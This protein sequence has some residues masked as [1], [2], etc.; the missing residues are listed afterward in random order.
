MIAGAS[1]NQWAEMQSL[2]A[3]ELMGIDG[4]GDVMA[5]GYVEFF[6]DEDNRAAVKDLLGVLTLD[7]SFEESGS[8]LA[9][10]TFVITGSLEH[11]ENRDACKEKIESLWRQDSRIRKQKHGLSH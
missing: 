4:I 9:G 2:S 5:S 1:R 7:E 10:K 6:A 8:A 3:E 11:F